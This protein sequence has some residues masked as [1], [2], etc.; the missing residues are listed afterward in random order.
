MRMS[1]HYPAQIC[2]IGLGLALCTSH[3]RA[4]ETEVDS[5]SEVHEEAVALDLYVPPHRKELATPV[6]PRQALVKNREGWVRLEFMVDPQGKAYEISVS[7]SM[8]DPLFEMAAIRALKKSTFEPARIDGQPADAGASQQYV[9]ALEG[10]SKGAGAWFLRLYKHAMRAI[11]EGDREQAEEYVASLE[12]GTRLNLYEDA[13]LHIAKFNYYQK[14]GDKHQ[15]LHALDRAVAQEFAE[16]NL[17]EELLVNCQRAR[18]MLLVET[19]DYER[20]VRTYRML[21]VMNLEEPVIEAL[22]TVVDQL[23]ALRADDRAYTVP[24]DFGENTSWSYHLFKDE[25]SIDA[26]QGDIAEIK[27]RCWTG[28]VFFRFQP[29]VKYKV[30]GGWNRCQLELVGNPGTTFALTQS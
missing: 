30:A 22:Q 18:F 28:Y 7:R 29:D 17:P 19:G 3:I 14:W 26:V 24:G 4:S 5:A 20:A 10:G 11:A 23:E 15:Q 25:F 21:K 6:Y 13:Y 8:G 27:L 1:C 12:K 9:F 2:A 16:K